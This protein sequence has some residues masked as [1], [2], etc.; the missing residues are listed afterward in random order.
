MTLFVSACIC[1]HQFHK[2]H[3]HSHTAR[4][5]MGV[6]RTLYSSPWKDK[7]AA[8]HRKPNSTYVSHR[9]GRKNTETT[10]KKDCMIILLYLPL[11]N[12][13]VRD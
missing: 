13:S 7:N 8:T 3:H 5:R 6:R 2:N 12:V 4:L 1:L 9:S 10:G 11:C